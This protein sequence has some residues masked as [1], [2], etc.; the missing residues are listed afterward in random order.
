MHHPSKQ[1][2]HSILAAFNLGPLRLQPV[3]AMTIPSN[4]FTVGAHVIGAGGCGAGDVEAAALWYRSKQ[5]HLTPAFKAGACM[6]RRRVSLYCAAGV[7]F[8]T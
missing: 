6:Q 3:P 7:L 8:N 5:R 4:A 1:Q 2:Q